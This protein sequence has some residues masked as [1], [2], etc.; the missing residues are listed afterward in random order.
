MAIMGTFA[1]MSDPS[2]A[3]PTVPS[4]AEVV[5]EP[6]GE[7]CGRVAILNT[8]PRISDDGNVVVFDS[9]TGT[10]R[11]DRA[12]DDP[13]PAGS[14][15]PPCPTHSESPPRP[16][17]RRLRR[18]L[19]LGA[20]PPGTR[21]SSSRSIAAPSTPATEVIA[22][23]PIPVGAADARLAATS[24]VR[25]RKRDR[26]VDRRRCG[27]LHQAR[28]RYW[29]RPDDRRCH[30]ASRRRPPSSR[31]SSTSAPMGPRSCSPPVLPR[32]PP[33]PIRPRTSSVGWRA[34]ADPRER[35]LWCPRAA[36]EL[37][38]TDRRRPRRSRRTDGSW[39]ISRT[40]PTSRPAACRPFRLPPARWPRTWCCSTSARRRR[41]RRRC[42]PPTRHGR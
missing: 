24:A 38:P 12:G 34:P 29:T 2:H 16:E 13:R 17:W 19:L 25:R 36:G 20:A 18:R 41:R 3:D 1:A 6:P 40:A 33:R 8:S 28:R 11:C 21:P 7:S 42:S 27:A 31:R 4:P 39:S 9:I 26:R 30:R 35:S 14:T 37:R 10:D 5:S 15:P 32:R 22:R 23:V